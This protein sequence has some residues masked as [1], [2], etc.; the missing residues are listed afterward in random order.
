MSSEPDVGAHIAAAYA[1]DRA[2]DEAAAV[3]HYDAA[4][5]LGV[6]NDARRHFLVGY[7]STLRN[8]GRAPEA[9]ALLSEASAADPSYVPF[10]VFLALA[11]HSSGAHPVAM[12]TLM[13]ALLVAGADLDGFERATAV[14]QRELLLG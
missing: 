2:G 9:V 14:Y 4:W 11:L 12:A 7:G 13:E 8:V 5:K 10:K 3:Q 1:L 6:P